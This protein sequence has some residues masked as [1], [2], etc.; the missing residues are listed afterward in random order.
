MDVSGAIV[1]RR[2]RCESCGL[3]RNDLTFTLDSPASFDE[4]VDGRLDAKREDHY[5][6]RGQGWW[7]RLKVKQPAVL[8]IEVKVERGQFKTH[9]RAL[10]G[11]ERESAA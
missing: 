1:V 9:Y 2:M 4:L 3:R 8:V 11:P 7:R 5:R 6:R 10:R